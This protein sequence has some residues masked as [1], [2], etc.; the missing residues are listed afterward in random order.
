MALI[1]YLTR[2]HFG[3]DTLA[4]L[5]QELADARCTRPLVVTDRGL[6]AAGVLDR[7]LE[8][9][10][11]PDLPVHEEACGDAQED[12][13]RRAAALYREAGCDGI[14]GLGGGAA[15]DQAKATAVL[16][17]DDGPLE[18]HAFF[19]AGMTPAIGALPP[20]LLVGTTAGT[21]AEVNR[22]CVVGLSGGRKTVVVLPAGSIHCA[23]ADPRLTLSLPP[24]ET[25]ATGIDAISHCIETYCSPRF[26]PPAD[27]IALDGLARAV[28]ALETAVAQGQDLAARSQML[29]ASIEGAL[30]FQKGLGAV[31]ALSHPLGALGAH[32][33]TLNGVLLPAVLDAHGAVLGPRGDALRRVLAQA[34]GAT[35]DLSA[36][37]A[38]R[39]LLARLQWPQRLRDVLP[40]APDFDAVASLAC[41]EPAHQTN[42]TPWTQADYLRVLQ[43][44]W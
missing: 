10:G 12:E 18:R 20:L 11:R 37:D 44:C 34:P 41:Q 40:V 33:G 36:G 22:G 28:G 9:L 8:A 26:N 17:R 7:L 3:A 1:Q 13:A 19:R 35:T 29:M 4:L 6:R 21:G 16:V 25:A 14:V 31:H 5:P 38:M 39:A 42:P 23:I 32:H 30:C 2:L 27:A 24:R 43:A 15:L